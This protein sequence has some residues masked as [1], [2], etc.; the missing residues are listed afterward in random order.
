MISVAARG[1]AAGLVLSTAA[2]A[3]PALAA[4]AA[5]GAGNPKHEPTFTLTS[6]LV[7]S[8]RIERSADQGIGSQILTTANLTSDRDA[9]TGQ[10][11]TM[12]V[13]MTGPAPFAGGE[14]CNGTW[15]LSDGEISWQHY[16]P[17]HAAPPTGFDIAITGGTGAY[18]TAAGYAHII[19]TSLDGPGEYQVFLKKR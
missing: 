17:P 5:A 8:T 4:E 1:A 10:E 18:S 2:L 13:Q 7:K 11:A 6:V 19:R 15:R 16:E 9:V 3:G 12:C 14:L